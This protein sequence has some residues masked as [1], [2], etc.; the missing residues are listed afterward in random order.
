MFATFL[1]ASF[2]ELVA[3]EMETERTKESL[4]LLLPQEDVSEY[5]LFRSK[6]M[7]S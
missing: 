7:F 3:M 1:R 2:H 5:S 6:A 4:C